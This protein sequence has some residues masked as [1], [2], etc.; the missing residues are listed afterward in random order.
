MKRYVALGSSMAAGPG[1]KP[2]AVGSPWAAG[3]SARNYAHLTAAQLGLD[4]V[5][6][7]YSG[8]TTANILREPQHGAPPQIGVVDGTEDLITVTIGGNDVG[9]VPLLFAATLPG[10][11]RKLPMVGTALRDLLDPA[12]RGRALDAAGVSLR[13]VG[14]ALRARSPEARILFV[15]YLT[16]LP[17]PG[18]PAPPL[19]DHIT[20]LGRYVADRL[21]QITAQAAQDTGCEVVGA[22]AASRDHHAWSADPW[23]VGAGSLLPWR[24]K[25]FHPN[26]R[27]M[28]AVA[29]LIVARVGQP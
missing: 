16:L 28:A 20:G 9:Y 25:P 17:P 6:V 26:A 29:D 7:T 3:R 13:E 14:A 15:D 22:A 19:P 27:G 4:L 18:I 2:R 21:V 1:I 5:D 23:T 10:L 24:P 8:A 11:L 12:A